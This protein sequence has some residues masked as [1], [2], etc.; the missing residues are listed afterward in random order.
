MYYIILR[1]LSITLPIFKHPPKWFTP[2]TPPPPSM[3]QEQRSIVD[4]LIS[5][6]QSDLPNYKAMP[7]NHSSRLPFS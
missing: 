7:G 1:K 4:L 2:R 5:E 3:R 6:Y